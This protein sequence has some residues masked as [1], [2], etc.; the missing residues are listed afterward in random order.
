M[1]ITYSIFL[2]ELKK[3]IGPLAKIFLDRAMDALG[4]DDITSE[5]YKDVLNVL[6]MNRKMREFVEIVE[7][8]LEELE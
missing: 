3:E 5:N 4:I 2:E 1:P 6:K 8:K 7:K